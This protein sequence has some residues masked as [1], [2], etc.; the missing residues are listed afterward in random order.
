MNHKIMTEMMIEKALEY[1]AVAA[2]IANIED[3]KG[4]PLCDDAETASYRPGGS[5]GKY[6]RSSGRRG[7]M[8]GRNALRAGD[9]F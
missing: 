9:R 5:C 1:G 2:G 4:S 3:L 6:D 7:S 8:G